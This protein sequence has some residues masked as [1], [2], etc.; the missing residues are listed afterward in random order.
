MK[1]K[2][3]LF[4]NECTAT[5]RYITQSLDKL[6]CYDFRKIYTDEDISLYTDPKLTKVRVDNNAL[7][8]FVII[9]LF[10]YESALR[11]LIIT[12]LIN[13]ITRNIDT[14]QLF[15]AKIS[16]I[17]INV[18]LANPSNDNQYILRFTIDSN[19]II[20]IMPITPI[21]LRMNKPLYDLHDI[22]GIHCSWFFFERFKDEDEIS[23]QSFQKHPHCI[24][25]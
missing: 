4:Q 6:M 11:L 16:V 1:S 5:E 20:D 8:R 14:K 24:N 17:E 23:W 25:R 15:D 22:S 7:F 19:S 21:S 3:Q 2:L 10:I 12:K 9:D 18:L 13:K